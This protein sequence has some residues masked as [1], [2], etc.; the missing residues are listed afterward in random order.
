MGSRVLVRNVALT[1]KRKLA[2][3]WLPDVYRMV[4]QQGGEDSPVYVIRREDGKKGERTLHRNLLLPCDILPL[5]AETRPR[6]PVR[7]S[8][9]RVDERS[10]VED[11]CPETVRL[12]FEESSSDDDEVI[13]EQPAKARSQASP[14]EDEE[15][16]SDDEPLIRRL[17]TAIARHE[18][19]ERTLSPSFPVVELESDSPDREVAARRDDDDH[20]GREQAEHDTSDGPSGSRPRLETRPP[21]RLE[22]DWRGRPWY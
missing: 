6:R 7:R 4:K 1:G 13:F 8:E 5:E 21:R 12:W 2:N 19:V 18:P 16:S 15:C 9:P 10:P 11:A 17:H 22:Y 20:A 3:N 14:T